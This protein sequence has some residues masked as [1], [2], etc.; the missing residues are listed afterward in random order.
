MNGRNIRAS[1]DKNPK[2]AAAWLFLHAPCRLLI[3]GFT[4]QR[5]NSS[6][7]DATVNPA[8]ASHIT[9]RKPDKEDCNEELYITYPC[10]QLTQPANLNHDHRS[11]RPFS[12]KANRNPTNETKSG[13]KY[14]QHNKN[15]NIAGSVN[16]VNRAT[17]RLSAAKG[18]AELCGHAR[19]PSTSKEVLSV[20]EM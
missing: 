17:A 16:N 2:A 9:Q 13:L 7:I 4:E 5:S 15:P 6:E 18:S 3:P 8:A 20:V 11:E 10:R 12:E 14:V 1:Q 19:N